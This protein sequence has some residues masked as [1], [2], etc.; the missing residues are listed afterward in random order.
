MP[1]M[2]IAVGLW[3]KAGVYLAAIESGF[4]I[5][6]NDIADKVGRLSGVIT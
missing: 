1:D 3:W 6:G 5:G 2:Q 4:D